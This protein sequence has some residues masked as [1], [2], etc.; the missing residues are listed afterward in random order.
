LNFDLLLEDARRRL[1]GATLR[2]V[3]EGK[4]ANSPHIAHL[5]GVLPPDGRP[6]GSLILSE[7]D[8]WSTSGRSWATRKL[9]QVLESP[10][11]DLL[12][13]GLSL[14]DPRLRSVLLARKQA[15]AG[16]SRALRKRIGRVF[17]LMPER[18]ADEE[19]ELLDRI[20]RGLASRYERQLW[21]SWNLEVVTSAS[22]ALVPFQLRQVRLG[23][24]ARVW[25]RMGEAFLRARSGTYRRLY[26][27]DTQHRVLAALRKGVDYFRSRYAVG[28]DEET[29]VGAF[30]PNRDRPGHVRMAFHLKNEPLDSAVTRAYADSRVLD[31]S[32][33][34]AP[35]GA[36]G[37]AFLQGVVGEA[38]RD[39]PILD[40]GF[41]PE[42][43]ANWGSAKT[44]SAVLSI[45]V[46]AASPEW[47]P[48]GVVYVTS[49]TYEPFWTRLPAGDYAELQV[50]LRTLFAGVMGYN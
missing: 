7:F 33:L 38:R 8:Y 49:N 24:D 45:P 44:F 47:V 5:H 1:G 26:E 39:S 27:S 34:E 21:D 10:N 42:M 22:Y 9:T 41:T 29:H 32:R 11:R 16:L 19:A 2:A 20:A 3:T 48:I 40:A 6:S 50:F 37:Y 14:T 28:R 17:V 30:V 15:I 46:Y 13:V 43:L 36:A 31:V 4:P 18:Q 12:L 25:T 35:Q 23:L